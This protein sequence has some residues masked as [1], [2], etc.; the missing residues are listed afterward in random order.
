M[1]WSLPFIYRRAD[2]ALQEIWGRLVVSISP[3]FD[4]APDAER[5]IGVGSAGYMILPPAAPRTRPYIG[6][7][8]GAK[9]SLWYIDGPGAGILRADYGSSCCCAHIA[10]RRPSISLSPRLTLK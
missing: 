8:V 5:A 4:D 3:S 7:P 10:R 9:R 6:P 2:G 1:E